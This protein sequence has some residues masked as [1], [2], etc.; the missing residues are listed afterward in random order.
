MN[1]VVFLF[2]KSAVTFS[3]LLHGP[4]FSGR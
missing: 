1:C 3:A 4:W 2:L